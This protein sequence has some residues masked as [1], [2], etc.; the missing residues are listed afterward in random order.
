[1]DGG[2]GFGMDLVGRDGAGDGFVVPCTTWITD[3]LITVGAT[4][5]FG[6]VV[7]VIF[8]AVVA[9]IVVLPGAI[10]TLGLELAVGRVVGCNDPFGEPNGTADPDALGVGLPDPVG[11]EVP[12]DVF[13][14][15][16]DEPEP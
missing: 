6:A 11:P 9:G 13:P 1:M 10:V 14:L 5:T 16:F 15:L 2:I 3:P 4:G 12:F 8:G 7:G